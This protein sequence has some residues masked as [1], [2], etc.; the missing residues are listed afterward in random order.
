MRLRFRR[1][2]LFY[3]EMMS[4]DGVDVDSL[5][6]DEVDKLYRRELKALYQ[7]KLD[8]VNVELREFYAYYDEQVRADL[9]PF[10][11]ILRRG[12]L[13]VDKMERTARWLGLKIS[14]IDQPVNPRTGK[15]RFSSGVNEDDIRR[16]KDHP[17][18]NLIEVKRGMARCPFHDDKRPSMSVKNNL[19]HCF[20]C[21][22]TWDSIAVSM[23]L[24]GLDFVTAVR[25]LL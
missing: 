20:S 14:L 7:K 12:L 6:D 21:Q 2:G 5:A 11:R 16:A 8:E 10:F 18:E 22:R 24:E 1:H 15:K 3:G 9:D 23:K 19:A 25:R 13:D 4:L 17:I